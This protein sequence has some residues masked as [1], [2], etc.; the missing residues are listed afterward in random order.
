MGDPV[1]HNAH[2]IGRYRGLINMD[3]GDKNPD[4]SP[5]LME[6]LHLEYADKA[7]LYVP[8]SQLQLIG[9]YTGVSAD[10][11]P[12]HKLGS[13][14]WEKAKRRAAEQVRDAAAEL[15]NIYARRAARAGPCL[16]LL[17]AR[18][19]NLRQRLWLRRNRRPERR[20]PRRHSRHD[21]P[22]THGPPGLRR[23]G[24]WQNRGRLA[25][26]LR[27]RD[28][29]AAG[30][31]PRADHAAGRAALPD[32]GGP[33]RQVAGE[34]RRD[35]PLPLTKGNH[36]RAQ[37]RGR[38][39]GGHRGRYPQAAQRKNQ[40]QR[41]GPAHHRRGAPVWRAPQGADETAARRGGRAHPHRHA[42]SA[43]AG[44]GAG[45]P[46]RSERDRHR[47]TAPP[48]H[49]DLCALGEQR[50]DPRSRVAR[51]EARR[52][53]LLPAQRSRDHRE[54]QAEAGRNPAR[55]AH[56]DCPWPDAR[57]RSGA[58][59]ARFC[60]AALQRVALLDH[61]RN[62]YRRAHRQHH[63]DGAGRQV[64]PGAA[65]PVAR[66]RGPQPPPS[67]CLPDG[68]RHRR[69]DQT[70]GPA[71]GCHSA[72]GRT[73][74]RLLPRHARSGDPRRGRSA[75]RKPERQHAGSGF[76]ALQRDA[77]RSRGLA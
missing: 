6:F 49:Q 15:L 39:H 19:R 66:P 5:A 64:W 9:R 34:D 8:V 31:L 51:T 59:D 45:R 35:E 72:N 58:G 47:A 61:H 24:L 74:Q 11:A 3:M 23:C 27:G 69:P 33:L 20:H 48:G 26:G 12:M 46:A 52:A 38:R 41:P 63:R 28:R 67:L 53:G 7:V 14:Q 62:R 43:H 1:V 10:E 70:G 32:A 57:A 30:G 4:G 29:R 75:G 65:A 13:G 76:P 50:R 25:R 56:R 22:A 40:I 16:P 37:G 68:A 17:G 54:P 60:G 73:G 21:Q 77:E 2:G 18:L 44:H 36:R 71:A 55:S 42:D